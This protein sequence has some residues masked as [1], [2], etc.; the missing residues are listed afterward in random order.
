MDHFG[1]KLDLED[2]VQV[3]TLDFWSANQ[4][5]EVVPTILKLDVEGHELLALAGTLKNLEYIKIVQFEFGGSNRDSKTYFQDFWYFF[6]KLKFKIYRI[7]P[8]GPV[9]I[10]EYSEQLETFRPTNYIAVKV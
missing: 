9:V 6:T 2:V 3:T 8:K 4:L 1:I 7:T 5:E 10:R